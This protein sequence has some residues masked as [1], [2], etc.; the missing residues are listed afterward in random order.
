ML[1]HQQNSYAPLSKRRIG[2][3]EAQS[4]EPVKK[5]KNSGGLGILI[6]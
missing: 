4:G 3:C 6:L 5:I 1:I 2:R